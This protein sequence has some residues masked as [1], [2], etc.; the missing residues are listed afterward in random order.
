LYPQVKIVIIDDNSDPL[1]LKA[2]VNMENILVIQS[3]FEKRGELLPYYYFFYN[4][5]FD[6]A[7][8]IHDSIFFHKK[9]CFEKLEGT[10]VLP[11]WHFAPDK[12]NI[13]NTFRISSYLNNNYFLQKKLNL[14][15]FHVLGKPSHE[16]FG[17]FGVQSYINHDFLCRLQ[18]KY[19]FINMVNAVNN[20]KDR[21]CLERIFGVL[22]FYESKNILGIKSLFGDI[23]KY[24]RWG[25]CYDEYSKDLYKNKK[26]PKSVVKIWTGR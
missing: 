5:F 4:K 21:C 20:R 16:W 17:C 3:Q 23:R 18:K 15:D 1:F 25:Y 26:L 19:N 22:F 10:P 12:E 14:S 6:N 2:N 9:I 24:Q 13:S 7:I 11:L 8:I